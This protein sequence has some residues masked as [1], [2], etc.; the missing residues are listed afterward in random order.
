[1]L[2]R[3]L[4]VSGAALVASGASVVHPNL[5]GDRFRLACS[6]I[7]LGPVEM[8]RSAALVSTGVVDLVGGNVYGFGL[9]GLPIR[10]V[11]QSR[12]VFSSG[13]SNGQQLIEG[14]IDRETLNTQIFVH[15]SRRPDLPSISMRFSCR[16]ASTL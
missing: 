6:G 11:S 9:G 15:G 16:V 7:I 13:G 4:M 12:I 3:L 8:V 1:M 5:P 14:R 10:F 2:A